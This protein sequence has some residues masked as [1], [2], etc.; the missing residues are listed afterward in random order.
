L[1]G[2]EVLITARAKL[3]NCVRGLIKPMGERAPRCDAGLF[4][5]RVET[6]LPEALHAALMPL[7]EE[8]KRITISI[9]EYDQKIT[10]L[11]C[12]K[13]LESQ[14]LRQ[15]PGV[16]A[17]TAVAF[18][19]TIGDKPRFERSRYVG[20]YLGL[21]PK[22]RQSGQSD[23]ELG[24]SKEG[25]KYVRKL[26]IQCAH[27]ILN[28]APDS[29]LKRWGLA[30]MTRGGKQGR[31]R[32]VTGVARKLAVLLHHLWVTGEVYQ[33]FRQRTEAQQAGPASCKLVAGKKKATAIR[34]LH[35][36]SA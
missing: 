3:I 31:K 18:V 9:Q 29:D 4:A 5:R 10:T 25:N 7:V 20:A 6:S 24:V 17:L 23:P 13:Y 34:P 11:A 19:M 33:R 35:A 14:L 15:V 26:L 2:R 16:G 28:R 36:I 12:E 21:T 8:I 32:A 22:Q 30:L 27:S 1:R